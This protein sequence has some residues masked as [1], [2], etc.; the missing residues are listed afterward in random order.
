MALQVLPVRVGVRFLRLAHPGGKQSSGKHAAV[1][2]PMCDAHKLVQIAFTA[3]AEVQS[4]DLHIG[5][6]VLSLHRQPT[7]FG[8]GGSQVLPSQIPLQHSL[9]AV[10][11]PP[12]D[13]HP[14]L[15]TP[16]THSSPSSQRLEQLPQWR[17]F[18]LR[19]TQLSL[20]RVRPVGIG[21]LLPR[22]LLGWRQR[23]HPGGR[24]PS[25]L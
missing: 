5:K 9:S 8:P 25:T 10:Q 6:S 18:L 7:K 19:F 12:F 17:S 15:Q 2:R 14:P 21:R 4:V 1:S 16:S 13:T 22:P 24:L 11:E 23:Q 20:H 3:G